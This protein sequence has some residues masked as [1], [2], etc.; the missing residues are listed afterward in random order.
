MHRAGVKFLAGTDTCV[1]SVPG[2]NLHDELEL[3]VRAGLPPAVALQAATRNAAEFFGELS[4]S[5]TVEPGKRA[6]LV[7]LEGDPLL[8]IGNTRKIAAVVCR[9]RLLE[10]SQLDALQR[11]AKTFAQ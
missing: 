1:Y 8:K 10:K 11:F 4:E 5:G 3:L 6:D 9:G 7:L 2:F